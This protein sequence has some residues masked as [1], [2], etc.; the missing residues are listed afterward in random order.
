MENE[1]IVLIKNSN[2]SDELLVNYA[3]KYSSCHSENH[4]LTFLADTNLKIKTEEV[5]II[6]TTTTAICLCRVSIKRP[7]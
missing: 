6:I 4:F 1:K 3:H 2:Y 5:I 7:N